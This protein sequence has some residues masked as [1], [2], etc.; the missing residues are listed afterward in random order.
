MANIQ[1]F[2]YQNN[3]VRTVDV[4]GEAWFVLKD[5]CEVLHLGTTAKVA[6]RLDDDEKGMNQIHTPGGTQNVTVVNE[7]G[8][9]HVILRSDK[10]EA[11]PFRRW[12]TNDVL[13]AIRKTGSYNAP[14]LT[15]S[16]LLATALIA[17][18]EELEEKD[19]RIKLLTA[20]TERMKP[21]EIFSDAVSTSQNS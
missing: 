13:P 21:K 7:S 8:L 4:D 19:K 12:V 15:R 5:V 2:E 17:A 9:Y 1:V 20:D 11:A 16:Q 14:Q 6:E 10:P 3:K 18:H